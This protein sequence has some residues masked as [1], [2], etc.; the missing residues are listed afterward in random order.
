MS[1]QNSGLFFITALAVYHAINYHSISYSDEMRSILAPHFITPI[2]ICHRIIKLSVP[3]A[4]LITCPIYRTVITCTFWRFHFLH[5]ILHRLQCHPPQNGSWAIKR[6]KSV[7]RTFL[8]IVAIHSQFLENSQNLMCKHKDS[9]LFLK[10]TAN[11][12]CAY[13]LIYVIA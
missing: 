4:F 3:L 2:T 8:H 12:N 5:K 7:Q 10:M 9:V 6:K 1:Y 13:Y 11:S